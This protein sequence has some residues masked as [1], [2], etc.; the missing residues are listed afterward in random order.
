MIHYT[1][2]PEKDAK[3]LK[4]EYRIRVFIVL[5]FFLSC[6]AIAGTV[7]LTPAYVIS[8]IQEKEL[9]DKLIAVQRSKIA[10]GVDVSIKE[11][12]ESNEV[13]KILNQDT[14]TVFVSSIIQ[15]IV[16]LKLPSATFNSIQITNSA[17]DKSDYEIIVQGKSS[18][19]EAL[20]ELKKSLEKNPIFS[21]V[22]FP[23]PDLTKSKDV[24][25]AVKLK[26]KNIK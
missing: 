16:G 22:E 25:F 23:I 11:L 17:G 6:V 3:E 5:L 8:S 20:L 19:R 14:P 24:A 9:N 1:L 2:L 18:T 13:L 7:S 15:D 4:T 26:F 10:R 12:S 21:K